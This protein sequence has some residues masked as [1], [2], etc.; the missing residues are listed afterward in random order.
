[1]LAAVVDGG[2]FHWQTN[3]ISVH[4]Y[5]DKYGRNFYIDVP[6]SNEKLCAWA[7]NQTHNPQ[8]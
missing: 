1:M 7:Q 2:D 6:Q 8:C 4:V 5:V 3:S